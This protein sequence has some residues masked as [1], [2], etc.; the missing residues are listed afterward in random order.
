MMK[1]TLSTETVWE[2]NVVPGHEISLVNVNG[3]ET[4]LTT[5]LT[6]LV[7]KVNTINLTVIKKVT[8]IG[9]NVSC[10]NITISGASMV[11][12]AKK[13]SGMNPSSIGWNNYSGS[14]GSVSIGSECKV[15]QE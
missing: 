13:G 5:P 1:V 8:E 15:T 6:P 7:A 9:E 11:V 4:I 3:I 10:G 2:A 12:Y 14:C